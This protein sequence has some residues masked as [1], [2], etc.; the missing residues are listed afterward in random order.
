MQLLILQQR[1]YPQHFPAGN[2]TCMNSMYNQRLPSNLEKFDA[3]RAALKRSGTVRKDVDW[4]SV[5]QDVYL[6]ALGFN[7]VWCNQSFGSCDY[8]LGI[9]NI[10][11]KHWFAYRYNFP[12]QTVE[13]YDSMKNAFQKGRQEVVERHA[14]IAPSLYNINQSNFLEMLDPDVPFKIEYIADVPQQHNGY[15]CGMYAIKIVQCLVMQDDYRNLQS[16]IFKDFRKK[17]AT[18]L[19]KWQKLPNGKFTFDDQHM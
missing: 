17:M 15:D 10:I 14:K 9:D 4:A 3:V 6:Y 12:K 5:D 8:I 2:W 11:E 19:V 18:D 16:G 7:D 1:K 13:V